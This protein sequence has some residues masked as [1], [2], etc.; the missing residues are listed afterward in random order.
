MNYEGLLIGL[1]T[2]FIIGSFHPL[3]IWLE[4]RWG[5]KPW[6]IFLVSG[7]LLCGASLFIHNNWLSIF[8]GVL[9]F[10]CLFSIREMFLQ[11]ERAKNGYA[12]RNPNRSYT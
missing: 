2:F 12:K 10:S 7:L 3:V 1:A 6:W 11:Y 5:K 4:Y 9:G 8:I